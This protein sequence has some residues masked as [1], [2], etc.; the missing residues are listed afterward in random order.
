MCMLLTIYQETCLDQNKTA[1]WNQISY[2][3]N[4]L[5]KLCYCKSI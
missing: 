2:F 4:Q 3:F 5:L 1:Y